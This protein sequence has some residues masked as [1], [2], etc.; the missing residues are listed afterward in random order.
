MGEVKCNGPAS[1]TCEAAV[2][3]SN[4][5]NPRIGDQFFNVLP[6]PCVG[7]ICGAP[8]RG[9]CVMGNCQCKRP[10]TGADCTEIVSDC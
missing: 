3:D 6:G 9:T 7:V 4:F 1:V 8:H 2:G 5:T 10:F